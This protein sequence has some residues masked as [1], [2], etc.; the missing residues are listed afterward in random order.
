MESLIVF[1]TYPERSRYHDRKEDGKLYLEEGHAS[2]AELI[3]EEHDEYYDVT[4]TFTDP[5]YRNRGL[6]RDLLDEIVE[7]PVK[8]I[9]KS[10]LHVHMWLLPSKMSYDDIKIK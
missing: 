1:T 4:S 2:I 3:Y 8:I 6:A 5:E 10:S 7:W 9:R